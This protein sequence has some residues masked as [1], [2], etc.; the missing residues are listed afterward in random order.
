MNGHASEPAK[1]LDDNIYEAPAK[2]ADDNVFEVHDPKPKV[3]V[4]AGTLGKF[5]Q[6][7]LL[8][9]K[10]RRSMTRKF[11][12]FICEITTPFVL[13][14]V[15]CGLRQLTSIE[16]VAPTY[17][18]SLGLNTAD[19]SSVFD[20]FNKVGRTKITYT[21]ETAQ[22]Q[23]VMSYI[24]G[25]VPSDF[26]L[27][28]EAFDTESDLETAGK[29][30]NSLM[31]A[32]VFES[33]TFGAEMTYTLRLRPGDTPDG[34]FYTDLTFP[35]FAETGPNSESDLYNTSGFLVM[36]NLA[37]SA[38]ANYQLQ[39]TN[40]GSTVLVD[41]TTTQ[42][43]SVQR[44]PYG[45]YKKN[46]FAGAVQGTLPLFIVISFVVPAQALVRDIV[47]EKERRLKETMAMMG[48][49]PSMYWFGWFSR[50]AIFLFVVIIFITIALDVSDVIAY[51]SP[52]VIFVLF[53]LYSLSLIA[54][55][56]LLSTFFMRAKVA[57]AAAG[58]LFFLLYM[59][60]TFYQ[61]EINTMAEG[62]LYLAC[63]SM[64]ACMSQALSVIGDYENAAIGAD[65]NNL[66]SSPV[67]ESEASVMISYIMLAF[68][69]V[70]Y[71]LLAVYID[72]VRPGD[73]GV[74]KKWYFIFQP[75]TYFG[76][77]KRDAE[78]R[79][80]A[81][82][83][84]TDNI[85]DF[86]NPLDG[87][88][89]GVSI[90]NL[91][92]VFDNGKVAVQGVNLDMK[93]GEI[94]SFLGHNGAG[95]STTTN[96]LSG[97]Y[98]PT[99]GTAFVDG[100]DI[101]EDLG[102]ARKALGLCPQHNTLFANLTVEE[103]LVFFGRLKGL[104]GAT[105]KDAVDEMLVDIMLADKRKNYPDELS[106]GMK[107]KLS[108]GIAFMGGT[109]IIFLDEPTAGM[110][111]YARRATWDLIRKYRDGRT[112]CLVTHYM[113]EADLLGDRIAIMNDGKVKACGTSYF[114]KKRYGVGYRLVISKDDS[115]NQ[116]G[117]DE[118][119]LKTIPHSEFSDDLGGEC[120]YTLPD[121]QSTHFA[122][123]FNAL[124]DRSKELGVNSFGVSLTT[125]ED[126]FFKL[127]EG[128]SL[129]D[130]GAKRS[131]AVKN[132]GDMLEVPEANGHGPKSPHSSPR[133]RRAHG[134][135]DPEMPS[136]D[137]VTG[138]ALKMK[139][140]GALFVKRLNHQKR[141][142]KIL[143][144][145]FLL[146]LVFTIMALGAAS[147]LE[148][149]NDPSRAIDLANIGPV[150]NVV[151]YQ[152]A[153]PDTDANQATAAGYESF[154][155]GMT[156]LG[157]GD[158]NVTFD[159]AASNVNYSEFIIDKQA[160]LQDTFLNTYL[161]GQTYVNSSD[162]T[163]NNTAWYN[164]EPI[165]SPPASVNL[166]NNVILQ[167]VLD[168]QTYVMN[169]INYPLPRTDEQAA[170]DS[171]E[172]FQ[173][174]TV[175]IITVFGFSFVA[176]GFALFPLTEAANSSK[177]L[178]FVSGVDP[179]QYWLSIFAFDF[180]NYLMP[181][182]VTLIV[183]AAFDE[184]GLGR[185]VLG[186]ICL[187]LLLF[188]WSAAPFVYFVSHFFTNP[189]KCYAFLTILQI[190]LGFGALIA[191]QVCRALD[192]VKV[193]D[194]LAWAFSIFPTFAFGQALADL[195][196]YNDLS[197]YCD[198]V[199]AR[200]GP[201]ASCEVNGIEP[202]SEIFS[203]DVPGIGRYV[204]LMAIEGFVFIGMTIG[205]EF[206]ARFR[207]EDGT[208]PVTNAV[209]ED[210][211]VA[212]ERARIAEGATADDV[213]V[214]RDLCKVYKASKLTSHGQ[215]KLAVD[216]I[217][218]GIPQRQCFGL[219]GI[220]GAGKTTTFK[221]L[222]G[223]HSVTSGNATIKDFSIVNQLTQVRQHT[224]YC[225][226]FD[227]ITP[228]LTGRELLTFYCHLRGIPTAHIEAYVDA[229]IYEYNL[230]KHA[231]RPC[232]GYSGGNKR[233]L[234]TAI[235]C[236]GD[237]AVV[238]LDEPSAGLD[239]EARRYLWDGILGLID[240]GRTVILTSHSMEECE[241]L[242]N[243]L[244]IMVNGKFKCMGTLQHLK[245]K[246]GKGVTCTVKVGRGQTLESANTFILNN[247][248]GSYL[249]EE[250]GELGVYSIPAAGFRYGNAFDQLEKAK[251]H[252][253]WA[254]YALS[255]TSLEQVFVNFARGQEED[256]LQQ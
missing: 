146:P 256:E 191:V 34:T 28:I 168:D 11:W 193:A 91:V 22:T 184:A 212:K 165:H 14:V 227:A 115:F 25:M 183:F 39:L 143:A 253:E 214:V 89:C 59:P 237:P 160:E 182:G 57:A 254:D 174:F 210:D 129:E 185:D 119:L 176:S 78:N 122:A 189:A 51:S 116:Y 46:D 133:M 114:L 109:R 124:E 64:N 118:I 245:S 221:M 243:R 93:R 213:V 202:A 123:A 131:T 43:T 48:L 87:E 177:H 121:D 67:F 105:L 94:T 194:Y 246:F 27:T 17:Y 216:R 6:F 102:E 197:T 90:R 4:E 230:D 10:N 5:Q 201:D 16:D 52:G 1:A 18:D 96:I 108:V 238:L 128:A 203:L 222:T 157:A 65:F 38:I 81:A 111:P 99:S 130:I 209:D 69:T 21:P 151:S 41:F 181:L 139:Q 80:K 195:P 73:Y 186:E 79:K 7:K 170:K 112:I 173:G 204:L 167:S 127:G 97:L 13:I 101:T 83:V 206:R 161:V 250:H 76:R 156:S 120:V 198:T 233:K 135:A 137:Y 104:A 37:E 26:P 35:A 77:K 219:L 200:F 223:E 248:P 150:P 84:N 171:F 50:M 241:A 132:S 235:A 60:Y 180:V 234:S 158:G 252:Y 117:V 110:D 100:W 33:G 42:T 95:K 169:L 106:G 155:L 140:F 255:Q 92:K 142:Y 136:F 217:S 220:N 154:L 62:Q 72:A 113:D 232:G 47:D 166:L 66:D 134:E 98:A 40:P 141:D 125:L 240:R 54:F 149:K 228:L 12:G 153:V 86:E 24:Q 15:L 32:I 23:Q 147:N 19:N 208:A 63:L 49:S 75:K 190:F 152:N 249:Q 211:D 45:E 236:V 138:N 29:N 36:Q 226:Q 207:K 218:F 3:Q 229:S 162:G 188:F 44:M 71:V 55:C 61:Q 145:Q 247:F 148:N 179:I 9:W 20:L 178:Q 58:A 103:H 126:V 196:R 164:G 199:R 88:N 205:W 68:D 224:G 2:E 8:A 159:E 56:F 30:D 192:E 172:S 163:L 244:A 85:G 31:G 215:D 53:F 74:P 107:R 70:L 175:G 231:D 144:I 187:I 242:C 82:A 239:V 225:P 251:H